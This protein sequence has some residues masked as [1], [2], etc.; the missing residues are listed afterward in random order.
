MTTSL[1]NKHLSVSFESADEIAL[2]HSYAYLSLDR[3]SRFLLG[4]DYGEGFVDVY[5]LNESGTPGKRVTALNEGRSTA[6]CI[7]TTPD[8]RFVYVPYVKENNAIYQ[9]R[10]D[11]ES[12]QLTA[13]EP[14][15]ANPPEGTGPRHM[16]YHPTKSSDQAG[17]LLQ[18]RT[19]SWCV[20]LR[21]RRKLK[22]VGSLAWDKNITS[23]VAR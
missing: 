8:N 5:A 3:T 10:F 6:H 12:G 1:A 21:H 11:A 17:C 2:N 4:A 7:L 23:I 18:Q 13:L 22:E 15:N 14:K 20:S 19:A 16:S 9:Y